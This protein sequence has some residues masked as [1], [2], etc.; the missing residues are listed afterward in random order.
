MYWISYQVL[1]GK[2]KP[3]RA[4]MIQTLLRILRILCEGIRKYK[5]GF[6][7]MWV[8]FL[9]AAKRAFLGYTY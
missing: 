6:C 8:A 3:V 7:L 9:R 4:V 5:K 1:S 2:Q